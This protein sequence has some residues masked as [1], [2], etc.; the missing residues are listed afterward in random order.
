[1]SSEAAVLGVTLNRD[2]LNEVT[3]PES[4]ATD[5]SFAVELRNEGEPVH[6]HLRFAGPLAEIASVTPP[7]HYVDG[8]ST[9][10]VRVSVASVDPAVEGAL[11]VIVGHGAEEATVPLRVD[12]SASADDGGSAGAEEAGTDPAGVGSATDERIRDGRAGSP[13]ASAAGGPTGDPSQGPESDDHGDW[14]STA[15]LRPIDEGI[16][17]AR[18]AARAALNGEVDVPSPEPGTIAVGALAAAALV[19][20]GIVATTLDGLAV[21]L[22]VVAVCVAVLVAGF[23]LL[24]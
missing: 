2:R 15:V 20:A 17:R 18:D 6:V 4:F 22:G 23:L 16:A 7:N 9:R 19:G 21:T 24:G 8:E 10:T 12:P 11:S 3:V 14:A 1:M 13:S 5:G